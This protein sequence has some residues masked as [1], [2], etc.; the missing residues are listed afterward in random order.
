L[1]A[2][3]PLDA[4]PGADTLDGAM[5]KT[6]LA[7]MTVLLLATSAHAEQGTVTPVAVP[8]AAAPAAV[9]PAPPPADA[10]RVPA[11]FMDQVLSY[12]D[13]GGGVVQGRARQP[14]TPEQLYAALDRPDLV[15]KSRAALRRR[16]ILGVAGGAVLVAGVIT[17]VVARLNL[18]N[19]NSAFCD[20]YVGVRGESGGVP[21]NFNNICVPETTRL[22]AISATG[23]IAGISLGGLLGSFAF[24]SKA[25]VLSK[26]ETST[27][28]SEH[29]GSLLR[30]LRDDR[31][32]QGTI[33][34]APYASSKGGGLTTV[35]TF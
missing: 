13:A 22:E 2:R 23:L 1:E 21:A 10:K 20:K 27:L 8:E 5:L 6:S 7:G 28:I 4:A 34:F 17:F 18:P 19:L 15:E 24:A 25:D 29:N 26:D 16:V 9:D 33:R 14:L 30:R 11:A 32:E 12:D 35:V 31:S 3:A